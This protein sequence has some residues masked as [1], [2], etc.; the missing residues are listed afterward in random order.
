MDYEYYTFEVTNNSQNLVAIGNVQDLEASYLIDQN[1]LRY[2][3]NLNET[4]QPELCVSQGQTKKIKIK[5]FNQYSSSREIKSLVLAR[6]ILNYE[7]FEGNNS[8]M[9]L[10]KTKYLWKK[11][12][13]L[14]STDRWPM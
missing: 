3:S 5:Y 11:G 6:I 8:S 1:D 14:I 4:A 7:V 9:K 2:T 13:V 12:K 10:G